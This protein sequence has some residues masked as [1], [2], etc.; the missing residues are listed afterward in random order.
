A[1]GHRVAVGVG[2][3]VAFTGVKLEFRV[4]LGQCFVA[5]VDRG[6]RYAAQRQRYQRLC[7]QVQATA[8]N[9][10]VYPACIPEPGAR[11]NELVV[12]R[13]DETL[14]IDGLA[15]VVELV[16]DDASDGNAPK[17]HGRTDIQRPQIVGLQHEAF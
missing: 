10:Q 13:I 2:L 5:E 6:E 15:V 3:G 11:G 7:V 14:A 12:G 8:V 4:R 9:G 1:D 16:A 17:I